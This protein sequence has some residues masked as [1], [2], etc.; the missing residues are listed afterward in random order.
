[1]GGLPGPRTRNIFLLCRMR[2]FYQN[3]KSSKEFLGTGLRSKDICASPLFRRLVFSAEGSGTGTAP[4][5]V[6]PGEPVLEGG[7]GFISSKRFPTVPCQRKHGRLHTRDLQPRRG[8]TLHCI[9]SGFR[10]T[11]N[12][13]P[14]QSDVL[15]VLGNGSQNNLVFPG[16]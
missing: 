13:L 8:F 14:F 4:G 12:P 3:L 10:K 15:S 2:A 5:A 1:M 6:Q 7:P 9:D 11:V 16:P